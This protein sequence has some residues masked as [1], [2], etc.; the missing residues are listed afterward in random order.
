MKICR[1]PHQHKPRVVGL[2]YEAQTN[3][4][5]VLRR[6]ACGQEETYQLPGKYEQVELLRTLVER[7]SDGHQ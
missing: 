1:Q 6:C 7:N 4:T 5:Q 3:R 2:H